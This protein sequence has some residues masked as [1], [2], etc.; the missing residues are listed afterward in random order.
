MQDNIYSLGEHAL[1]RTDSKGRDEQWSWVIT[2]EAIM[3]LQTLHTP[4]I[5]PL[6]ETGK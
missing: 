3:A 5:E 1:N 4:S 2:P 6:S